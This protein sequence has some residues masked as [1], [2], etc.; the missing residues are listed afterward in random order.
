V[1]TVRVALEHRYA[2]PTPDRFLTSSISTGAR[3]GTWRSGDPDELATLLQ[4]FKRH[5]AGPS[6][7]RATLPASVCLRRLRLPNLPDS[8]SC[9]VFETRATTAGARRHAT[10]VLKHLLQSL[11]VGP[12]C[13]SWCGSWTLGFELGWFFCGGLAAARRC[14]SIPP[15]SC[16]AYG[17]PRLIDLFGAPGPFG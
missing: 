4:G 11:G 16:R 3:S 10:V 7:L 9:L 13:C 12:T 14:P 2:G 17:S 6:L 8:T 5:R 15:I 1:P